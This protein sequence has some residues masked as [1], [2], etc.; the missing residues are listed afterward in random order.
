MVDRMLG[1]LSLADGLAVAGE[2]VFDLIGR[3]ID[4]APVR[5]LLGQR[6][7]PGKG[8]TS[9]PAEPLLRSLLLG[10]WHGFGDP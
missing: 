6:S 2:T 5:A 10:T 1:Q 7:G 4:W 8:N 3:E 9:Y